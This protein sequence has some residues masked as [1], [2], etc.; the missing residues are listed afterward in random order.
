MLVE[1]YA[2]QLIRDDGYR[3]HGSHKIFSIHEEVFTIITL[4]YL[5]KNKITSQNVLCI[6]YYV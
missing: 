3:V 5:Y 1:K 6:V 4:T 2:P